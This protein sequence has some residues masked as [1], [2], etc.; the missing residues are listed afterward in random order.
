MAMRVESWHVPARRFLATQAIR[1]I[2]ASVRVAVAAESRGWVESDQP[3]WRSFE[4]AVRSAL[5]E[6]PDGATFVDLGG[7]R[8]CVY[9]NSVPRE[10]GVRLV[11]V[12]ISEEELAHNTAA[13]ATAVA[14]V[15][16]GLPF[17]DESVDL[18]VSRVVLEHVDGV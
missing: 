12:D 11:A 2:A 6:L 10:R 4:A 13:D 14:D 7:G 18:L 8:S 17:P 3:F 9:A 5:Q 16:N 15:A 1:M